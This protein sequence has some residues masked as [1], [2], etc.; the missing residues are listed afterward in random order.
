MSSA[1]LSLSI[2]SW[3]RPSLWVKSSTGYR[4]LR[5][6][7]FFLQLW[8]GEDLFL[9]HCQLLPVIYVTVKIYGAWEMVVISSPTKKAPWLSKFYFKKERW[10]FTRSLPQVKWMLCSHCPLPPSGQK[11]SDCRFSMVDSS[12]PFNGII[13][14]TRKWNCNR[15]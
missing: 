2:R 15:N 11:V 4:K 1:Y 13:L 10:K 6:I 12:Y 9:S 14:F 5:K 8:G 3:Y 7:Q